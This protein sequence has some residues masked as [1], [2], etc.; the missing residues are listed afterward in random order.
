M[1]IPAIAPEASLD[2][3][4]VLP[5]NALEP[6]GRP[7]TEWVKG[8]KSKS[9]VD[10]GNIMVFERGGRGGVESGASFMLTHI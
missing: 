6:S 9:V 10:A 7:A 1:T 8:R 5:L 4:A 2:L 3:C